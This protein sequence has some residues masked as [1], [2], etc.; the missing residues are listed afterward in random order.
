MYA[1]ITV[2]KIKDKSNDEQ[3]TLFLRIEKMRKIK[4]N[5]TKK[6]FESP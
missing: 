6:E 2:S 1:C 5:I 4:E 3:H